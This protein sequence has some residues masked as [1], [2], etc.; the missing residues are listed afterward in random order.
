MVEKETGGLTNPKV[1]VREWWVKRS[2]P[3][4]KTKKKKKW[5]RSLGPNPAVFSERKQGF[6][7]LDQTPSSFICF[8][9]E[10][11]EKVKMKRG[12]T[13]H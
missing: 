4:D 3:Q 5:V 11:E 10:N 6:D 9:E 8:G 2:H 1:W 13:E 7:P 12:T